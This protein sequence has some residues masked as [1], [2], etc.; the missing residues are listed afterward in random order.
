[1]R[2]TTLQWDALKAGDTLLPPQ[3][4]MPHG[5]SLYA[6]VLI[7]TTAG[8]VAFSTL[9]AYL[10]KGETEPVSEFV[11]ITPEPPAAT[12]PTNPAASISINKPI[13]PLTNSNT[14]FHPRR[15]PPD[16]TRIKLSRLPSTPAG[17]TPALWATLERKVP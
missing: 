3:Q 6:S 11:S 17:K 8:T 14:K 7:A 4:V 13:A 10:A 12:E 2:L 1:M 16:P 15:D 9:L 5:W